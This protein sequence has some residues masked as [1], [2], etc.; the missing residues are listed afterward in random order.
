MQ[1]DII[2][3]LIPPG[4]WRDS[5]GDATKLHCVISISGTMM[6]LEAIQV[7]YTSDEQQAVNPDLTNDFLYLSLYGSE[8]PF[9]TTEINGKSYVLVATP[10]T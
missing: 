8:G 6:H 4:M 7:H 9:D 3:I 2:H 1:P 5:R 10:F